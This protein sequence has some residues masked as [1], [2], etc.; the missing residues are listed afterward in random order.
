MEREGFMHGPQRHERRG[1]RGWVQISQ[2]ETH[3]ESTWGRQSEET[4]R[5]GGGCAGQTVGGGAQT[6]TRET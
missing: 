2:G 5:E 6:Q 3:R 4:E 1:G